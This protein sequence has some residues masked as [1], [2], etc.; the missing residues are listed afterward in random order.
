M[1]AGATICRLVLSSLS[2][3]FQSR[4]HFPARRK[5]TPPPIA[6]EAPRRRDALQYFHRSFQQALHRSGK[7]LAGVIHVRQHLPDT[8][9]FGPVFVRHLQGPGRPVPSAVVTCVAWVIPVC[10]PD[11]TLDSGYLPA[12]VIALVPGGV[13]A[14]NALGVHDAEAG[15][16]FPTTGLSDFANRC[17]QDL[18]QNGTPTH[19][20]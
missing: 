1:K 6:L 11:I 19:V 17:F 10:S 16:L 2:Q 14:L 5:T 12:R 9:E 3:L 8:V 7:G 4:R 15:L 18:L 13:C 20:R